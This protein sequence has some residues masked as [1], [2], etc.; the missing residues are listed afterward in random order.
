MWGDIQADSERV[1]E[2]LLCGISSGFPLANYFGLPGS[3]FMFGISQDPPVC[4]HAT[5][6]YPTAIVSG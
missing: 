4:T 6:A 5:L 2:L 1:A 3:E